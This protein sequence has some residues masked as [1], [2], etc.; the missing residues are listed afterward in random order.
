[1]FGYDPNSR[2]YNYD[3]QNYFHP[4]AQRS[5]EFRSVANS[6]KYPR[7]CAPSTSMPFRMIL[8]ESRPNKD[9]RRMLEVEG[10]H[11]LV[12]LPISQK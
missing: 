7:L 5:H 4:L 6:G 8:K 9:Y 3:L 2:S 10:T 1:M 12:L 11:E